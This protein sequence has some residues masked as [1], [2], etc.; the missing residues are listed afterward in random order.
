MAQLSVMA[1]EEDR[2]LFRISSLE[3]VNKLREEMGNY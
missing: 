1:E 2:E 3:M